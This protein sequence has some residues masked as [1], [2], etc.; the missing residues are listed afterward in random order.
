MGGKA[1]DEESHGDDKTDAHEKDT[2][3]V[4]L[5]KKTKLEN[6]QILSAHRDP[7]SDGEE[8]VLV[9]QK[10]LESDQGTLRVNLPALE[11]D[12]AVSLEVITGRA[13]PQAQTLGQV[14]VCRLATEIET[15][16]LIQRNEKTDFTSPLSAQ[17]E[18]LRQ[19]PFLPGSWGEQDKF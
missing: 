1:L 9:Q 14:S 18:V 16:N 8:S 10:V 15:L 19:L 13:G 11:K 12:V 7:L 17:S 2:V 6:R 4:G 3:P 5:K